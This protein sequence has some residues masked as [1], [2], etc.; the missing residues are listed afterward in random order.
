MYPPGHVAFAYLVA[1]PVFSK[2][3]GVADLAA[4]TC[5]SL[6][7]A[8]SGVVLQSYPVF[9]ISHFWGHSPLLIV[10]LLIVGFLMHWS[11]VPHHR[12]PLLFAL[13][14][15]S[16]LINDILFD[17][18]L[19]YF[20]DRVDDMGGA[21]FYPWRPIIIRYEQPGF[22]IQPWELILEGV[23]LMW[24][25]KLWARRDLWLYATG[26]VAATVIWIINVP[27]YI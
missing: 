13:G 23:F 15:A 18:P 25:L 19:I 21:W 4:L 16:H 10:P 8:V 22:N 2:Q 11:K 12:V 7:P 24:T 14:V 1:K 26:V 3:L 20:S 27:G 6:F 9:G 5:G 17:F